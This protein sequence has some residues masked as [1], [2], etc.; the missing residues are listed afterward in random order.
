MYGQI[1]ANV[2]EFESSHDSQGVPLLRGKV[3][4]DGQHSNASVLE[5]HCAAPEQRCVVLAV[6]ERVKHTVRLYVRAQHVV[7]SHLGRSGCSMACTG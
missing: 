1:L 7:D 6:A 2:V 3:A 5:L 4:S